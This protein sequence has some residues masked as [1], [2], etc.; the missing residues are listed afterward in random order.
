MSPFRFTG[1][2]DRVTWY[3]SCD[4]LTEQ[5]DVRDSKDQP[6]T[7]EQISHKNAVPL[8]WAIQSEL[9]SYRLQAHGPGG[10]DL[11]QR[12]R[13]RALEA[14]QKYGRTDLTW[15]IYKEPL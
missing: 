15:E 6:L 1:K 11:W 8:R 13:Q 5:I 7:L 10:V 14:L 12:C 4:P 2:D 9:R 3:L